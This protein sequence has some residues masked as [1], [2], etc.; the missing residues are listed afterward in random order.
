VAHNKAKRDKPFSDSEFVKQCVM[1]VAETVHPQHKRAFENISLF[2]ITTAVH[3]EEM[4]IDLIQFRGS[5]I[6]PQRCTM[7]QS[8]TSDTAQLL[9]FIRD[10]DDNFNVITGLL[11]MYA[12]K[13]TSG[14]VL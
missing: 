4:D 3:V 9:I 11:P 7:V 1:H 13:K 14:Y 2:R 10:A 6:F 8:V 12:M 5:R